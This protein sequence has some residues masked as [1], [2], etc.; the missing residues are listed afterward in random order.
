[1]GVHPISPAHPHPGSNGRF[2]VV[3]TRPAHE[4]PWVSHTG[5][6]S[7]RASTKVAYCD[8]RGEFLVNSLGRPSPCPH[9]HPAQAPDTSIS[10]TAVSDAFGPGASEHAAYI[11]AQREPDPA[12]RGLVL[13]QFHPLFSSLTRV[14]VAATVTQHRNMQLVQG[15]VDPQRRNVSACSFRAARTTSPSHRVE[16]TKAVDGR[17]RARRKSTS[18]TDRHQR[19]GITD[20]VE[21]PANDTRRG[22]LS[23]LL[24]QRQF[25]TL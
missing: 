19:S 14:R 12:Q 10:A 22:S 8:S 20:S 6:D 25:Q 11:G 15:D 4:Q 16:S 2:P 23:G 17:R 3:S 18:R 1:M 9:G 13:L 5:N 21:T 7:T 24:F